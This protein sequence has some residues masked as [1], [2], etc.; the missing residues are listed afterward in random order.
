MRMPGR[1]P[2]SMNA[3]KALDLQGSGVL[4]LIEFVVPVFT[5]PILKGY[6]PLFLL[7]HRDSIPFMAAELP[8]DV[9]KQSNG[10]ADHTHELKHKNRK[11]NFSKQHYSKPLYWTPPTRRY[12]KSRANID[13]SYK[14]IANNKLILCFQKTYITYKINEFVRKASCPSAA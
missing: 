9:G 8:A 14:L 7:A 5:E 1:P 13:T 6:L 10:A 4:Q 3:P 11:F 2:Q 12:P